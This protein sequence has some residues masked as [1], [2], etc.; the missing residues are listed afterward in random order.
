MIS[1]RE[2]VSRT[3]RRVFRAT[4][5]LADNSLLLALYL[6][7]GFSARVQSRI[8]GATHKVARA[9]DFDELRS[10]MR[11]FRKFERMCCLLGSRHKPPPIHILYSEVYI[12]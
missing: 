5:G 11:F 6:T 9:N 2:D 7:T 10:N 4:P 8:Q 3:I 12:R 1:A